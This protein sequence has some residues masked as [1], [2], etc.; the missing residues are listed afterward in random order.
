MPQESGIKKNQNINKPTQKPKKLKNNFKPDQHY[1][2]SNKNDKMF[3]NAFYSKNEHNN[4][5]INKYVD[6]N[7][8]IKNERNTSAPHLKDKKNKNNRVIKNIN[9]YNAGFSPNKFST[10]S[11]DNAS[12]DKFKNHNK[13]KRA[14][15]FNRNT[16]VNHQVNNIKQNNN[17]KTN[18]K[19]YN[20][21]LYNE[22]NKE[23]LYKINLMNNTYVRV[24]KDNYN[25][26]TPDITKYKQR[27][28]IIKNNNLSTFRGIQERIEFLRKQIKEKKLNEI[29]LIGQRLRNNK[30]KNHTRNYNN[31]SFGKNSNMNNTINYNPVT[32]MNIGT[33]EN[34]NDKNIEI[35]NEHNGDNME[36]NYNSNYVD[37]SPSKNE[38]DESNYMKNFNS[39]DAISSKFASSNIKDKDY[40]KKDYN[41]KNLDVSGQSYNKK[42]DFVKKINTGTE[43][44]KFLFNN[45]AKYN[46]NRINSE[47]SK[48]KS[49]S[50]KI[51]TVNYPIENEYHYTKSSNVFNT[52][53]NKL[54]KSSISNSNYNRTIDTSHNKILN[55]NKNNVSFDKKK[56]SSV[57]RIKMNSDVNKDIVMNK[58]MAKRNMDK[59]KVN[60]VNNRSLNYT[61]D[62]TYSNKSKKNFPKMKNIKKVENTETI[63]NQQNQENK[64]SQEN[65]EIK[66][67]EEVAKKEENKIRMIDKIG[68]ICHAGEISYGNPKINQDNYF[69]YKINIDD[70]V[71]VGV[72]DG[73]GENGHYVSEYLINHL[74]QDFN[75]TYNDL[76]QKEQKAFDDISLESITKT[77]EESFLK[78][79]NGLNE[80]CDSMKKKKLTGENVDNYF[81]CDYSGSTCVSI[82]LKQNDIKKVYIANV[83]DS[84]TI[85]I[86]E[87][88]K[89]W[90]CKQ[91]SRDHK[92]TEKD[93]YNR[94]IEA[95]GEIEAIEDDN[96]NWTG[97]LRVWEKGSE[98]PGL[99]MTRSLGDKVGTKIGVVCTPEVFKYFIKEED[100]AFIIASD[101][102]WEY[103]NNQDVTNSVKELI[104]NMRNNN[105]NNEINADII[106]KELFNQSIERWRKKE[107]GIDD[108]TIICVLLK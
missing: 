73:H 47:K 8:S 64:E 54:N 60:R 92:P 50:K 41:K 81:N 86:R 9:D 101:G 107:Q 34:G 21:D 58:L 40:S 38:K 42:N 25:N 98:G 94:I 87:K 22:N 91:L 39:I 4:K 44:N 1:I 85:V 90:T 23:P 27:N 52:I 12:F 57:K 26:N 61:F 36:G 2:S 84:R 68:C 13:P 45:F 62:K 99:A 83:G 56:N 7:A 89:H 3:N 104:T 28:P 19:Y 108:I 69:N 74:P 29:G 82:L 35:D 15:N 95:D 31:Q 78:T 55:R 106:T 105:K 100:R 51:K 18:K 97:P 46:S 96:G 5:N 32:K 37:I 72:C 30:Q 88:D 70:L 77:F 65:Q 53:K 20:N 71:F 24:K 75:E 14:Y 66:Q 48:N 33:I 103:M 63:D 16:N 76:K 49:K 80:F 67:K 6:V 11:K 59:A 93:E 10:H 79:D 43:N 17:S 102:L